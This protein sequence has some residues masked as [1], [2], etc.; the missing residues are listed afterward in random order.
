M[1][2]IEEIVREFQGADRQEM[3][4]LLIDYS[5]DLPEIPKRFAERVDRDLHQVHECETPVFIWVE[6]EDGKVNIFA[7][8]PEP[9]P[10]V[11]G[12]VSILVSAF[13]GLS[14]EEIESAPVDFIS[15]LG[16]AQKLG[17]RRVRG[18]SAVYARIKSEVRRHGTV[19]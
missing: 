3:I 10:T 2:S 17:I 14:P 19:T 6:M 8:V 9:F 1:T 5:E 15:Q 4:E 13:D 18:L 16:I 12:L 11:R 7:D